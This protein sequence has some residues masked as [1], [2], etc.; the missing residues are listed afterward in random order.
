MINRLR[1]GH[2]SLR[3]NLFRFKIVDSPLCL[4]CGVAETSNHIFWECR[5]YDN[6]RIQLT[7]DL[8]R[9]RGFLP[10]SVEYIMST[11]DKNILRTLDCFIVA[12]D[13]KI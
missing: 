12:C 1:C 11:L 10:H 5:K 6:Q 9:N 2:T 8:V 13:L 3:A 4:T 7:S